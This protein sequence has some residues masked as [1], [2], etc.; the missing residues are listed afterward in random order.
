MRKAGMV[1][2][3]HPPNIFHGKVP[4]TLLDRYLNLHRRQDAIIP[5]LM[6]HD[7]IGDINANGARCMEAIFDV[8]P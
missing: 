8:K 7:Y 2:S 4:G 3:A 6:V 5:D 1:V